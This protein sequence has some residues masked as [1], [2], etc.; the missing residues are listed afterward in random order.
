MSFILSDHEGENSK[1]S[2]DRYYVIARPEMLGV[3]G[4]VWKQQTGYETL[5][6]LVPQ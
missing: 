6:N 5:A 3:C 4:S 1:I 2:E